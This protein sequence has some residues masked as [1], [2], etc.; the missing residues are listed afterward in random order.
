MFPVYGKL[1]IFANIFFIIAIDIPSL[2][3]HEFWIEPED[4]VIKIGKPLIANLRIGQNFKGDDLVFNEN[5]FDTFTIISGNKSKKVTGRLGD[6]PPLNEVMDNLGLSIIVH[7]SKPTYLTYYDFDKFKTFSTEKGFPDIPEIH[8]KR[9]LPREGFSEKY[10]RF[11]KSLVL[12]DKYLGSDKRIGLEL[13]F[14]MSTASLSRINEPIRFKLY[15][16]GQLYPNAHVQVFTKDIQ[17]VIKNSA[18]VTDLKGRIQIKYIPNTTSLINAV[19]IKSIDPDTN[20]G[21]AVW[22][23]LWASTTFHTPLHNSK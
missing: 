1:I 11:A 22:E 17:G 13:E 2:K 3:S 14:V 20:S 9:G 19:V 18:Y 5:D 23:S 6:R 8:I 4:Y 12:V 21:G 16:K 7:Q 15:Y 10:T